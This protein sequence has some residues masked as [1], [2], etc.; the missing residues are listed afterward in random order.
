MYLK[1]DVPFVSSHRFAVDTSMHYRPPA[2]DVLQKVVEKYV[3][4]VMIPEL[5]GGCPG[6][7]PSGLLFSRG[8]NFGETVRLYAY[9][10]RY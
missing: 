4:E 7:F 6:L 10:L 9:W 3:D 1:Y 2:G 5:N 8:E